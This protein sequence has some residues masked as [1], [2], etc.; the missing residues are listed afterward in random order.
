VAKKVIK[1]R[2]KPP[3]AEGAAA[4]APNSAAAE[5]GGT[6]G[7]FTGVLMGFIPRCQ[8]SA[9]HAQLHLLLLCCITHCS[10]FTEGATGKD[11]N[12]SLIPLIWPVVQLCLYCF[13]SCHLMMAP[14]C[15]CWSAYIAKQPLLSCAHCVP[16]CQAGSLTEVH[17]MPAQ[18]SQVLLL[19]YRSVVGPAVP[20]LS[21]PSLHGR[22]TSRNQP[23]MLLLLLP[24]YL[25]CFY[26]CRTTL[27]RAAVYQLAF[28]VAHAD[29]LGW[30]FQSCNA[31]TSLAWALTVAAA[32]CCC[33]GERC[34]SKVAP[35]RLAKFA[36][37][38]PSL[39]LAGA[40]GALYGG[41]LSGDELAV[42][43]DAHR[44]SCR[45][46]TVCVAMQACLM[47]RLQG[48]HPHT[49]LWQCSH[50]SSFC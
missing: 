40:S 6:N 22:R 35:T 36:L 32:A 30:G 46:T 49:L 37:S 21:T 17:K 9:L 48:P 28:C 39:S 25:Y 23:L 24:A 14:C 8:M 27:T 50:S 33:S 5:T 44:Q 42:V 2:T 11:S 43:R 16:V 29:L 38:L 15:I 1:A 12:V 18:A 34:S 26:C 45:E 19:V 20:G 4:P 31:S 41:A 7:E 47:N 10:Y 3:L 13:C